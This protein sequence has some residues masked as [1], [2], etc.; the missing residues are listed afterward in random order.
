[1]NSDSNLFQVSRKD[2]KWVWVKIQPPANRRF[3]P[4]VPFTRA[5]HFGVPYFWPTAKCFPN[6]NHGFSPRP[7]AG[8]VRH[9]SARSAAPKAAPKASAP[10]RNCCVRIRSR[11]WAW[12]NFS[13]LKSGGLLLQVWV[14]VESVCFSCLLFLIYGV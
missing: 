9:C 4:L 8:A 11:P 12:Q 1:M 5:S 7:E 3:Y 10:G 6:N 14:I 2:V 13:P